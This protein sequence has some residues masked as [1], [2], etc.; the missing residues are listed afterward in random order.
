MTEA[1]TLT[2][3]DCP[4]TVTHPVSTPAYTAKSSVYSSVV[5]PSGSPV[6]YPS[7]NGTV[8]SYTPGSPAGTGSATKSTSAPAFTGAANKAFA[9][10]GAGLAG[11]A[12]FLAYVL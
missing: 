2:I 3:S 12:G 1:T 10:S 6:P 4:C 7:S 5:V 9:A 11:L 8:T